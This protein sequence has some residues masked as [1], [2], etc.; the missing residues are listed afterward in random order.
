MKAFLFFLFILFLFGDVLAQQTPQYPLVTASSKYPGSGILNFMLCRRTQALY[1]PS[2]FPGAPAGM[3]THLYLRSA[4]NKAN[5][6]TFRNLNIKMAKMPTEGGINVDTL[7]HTQP[8]SWYNTTSVYYSPNHVVF[9]PLDSGD[10]I[11]F[12]L[13]QPFYYDGI[14]NFI[15]EMSHDSAH[16]PSSVG[17]IHTVHF[18]GLLRTYD[19]GCIPPYTANWVGPSGPIGAVNIIGFDIQ[20]NSIDNMQNISSLNL[21]PN[22]SH[23]IFSI[24]FETKKKMEDIQLT[25]TNIMGTVILQEKHQNIDGKFRRQFDLSNTPGGIYF[26]EIKADGEKIT[27]KVVVQ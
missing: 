5:N 9:A 27:R 25:V 17:L 10:W 20:P 16:T 24:N 14:T 3:I 22:P 2:E 6:C 11:Q 1:K 12:P 7:L 26:A 13:Q 19:N 4:S 15:V 18:S 8:L 21:F 23:G